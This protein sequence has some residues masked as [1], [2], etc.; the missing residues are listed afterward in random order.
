MVVIIDEIEKGQ[1]SKWGG[2]AWDLSSFLQNFMNIIQVNWKIYTKNNNTEINMDNWM[3]IFN[4]NLGFDKFSFDED[5]TNRK[6][7]FAINDKKERKKV[8]EIDIFTAEDFEMILKKNYWVS[9]SVMNRLKK[10]NN[11]FIFNEISRKTYFK[12]IDRRYNELIDELKET[13]WNYKY[14]SLEYFEK[15]F[16][17]FDF[18]QWFRGINDIIDITIK[19]KILKEIIFKDF[20]KKIK[21]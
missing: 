11:F 15:Y 5:N 3:F 16:S 4:S 20:Y 2:A 13:Y 18:R 6:I 10:W 1:I 19:W 7:W 21:F 17:E 8:K 14:P 12:H 9:V